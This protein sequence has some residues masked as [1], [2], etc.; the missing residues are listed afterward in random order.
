M[1]PIV[2]AL[3]HP[4]TTMM[5]VVALVGGGALAV[6]RMRIDIFPPIN[7]PQIFVNNLAIRRAAEELKVAR[8]YDQ[9]RR[10]VLA[11]FGSNDFDGFDLALDLPSTA[12][13]V[14]ESIDPAS[15]RAGSSLRWNKPGTPRN[16]DGSAA[17][18]IALDLRSS[19]NRH[20][21]T[22]K[23]YRQYSS[24]QLQVDVN[25]LTT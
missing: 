20:C 18:T 22:L 17:W 9:I 5:L 13:A 6:N 12:L 19:A 7:Q 21:G 15:R 24:R 2:F 10:I 3:R 14:L 23:V 25:L 11:A 8:D 16:L 1:N 4:I